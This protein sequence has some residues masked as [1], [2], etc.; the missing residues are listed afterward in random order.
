MR[1]DVFNIIILKGEVDFLIGKFE[2][3]FYFPSALVIVANSLKKTFLI[4]FISKYV[5]RV[6][7]N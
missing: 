7:A 4:S 5:F 3:A 1:F 6:I 2:E